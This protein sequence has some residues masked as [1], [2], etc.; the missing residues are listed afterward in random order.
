MGIC[1]VFDTVHSTPFGGSWTLWATN[2]RAQQC[3]MAMPSMHLSTRGQEQYHAIFTPSDRYK[4]PH[5]HVGRRRAGDCDTMVYATA[6]G[7]LCT[8]DMSACASTGTPVWMPVV[9]FCYTTSV[10]VST[11][12]WVSVVYASYIFGNHVHAAIH[13]NGGTS[14]KN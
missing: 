14:T 9:T 7:I 3:S 1:R 13:T 11:L 5:I 6:Y 4:S 8:R 12:K 2:R 10:P